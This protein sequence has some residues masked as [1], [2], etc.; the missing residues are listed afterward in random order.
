M[1]QRQDEAYVLGTMPLGEADLVVTLLSE[2]WGRVRGVARS[3]RRSR[4]RFGGSLAPMSRVRA[5]WTERREGE[6]H[7]IE[8]VDLHR[9]FASMQSEPLV[10]AACALFAEIGMAAVREEQEERATFRL[11]GAVLE[12]MEAGLSAWCAV[13]YFE[14]WLLRLHG[15]F[16]DLGACAACGVPLTASGGVAA[17]PGEGLAC[18]RCA[19]SRAEA[20]RLPAGERAALVRIATEPP[21]RIGDLAGMC[22]PG[23]A[24]AKILRASAEIFLERRPKAYRH[25]EA[26]A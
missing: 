3:A 1:R 22:G 21:D 4:I 16:A 24:L 7:R 26:M 2:R 20:I 9:S 25:L 8:S 18:G 15:V 6:L 5:I 11:Y 23:G 13:R 12:A 19:H 14:F 10:Q 17:I